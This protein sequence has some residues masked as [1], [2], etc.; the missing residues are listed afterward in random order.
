[1]IDDILRSLLKYGQSHWVGNV[2]GQFC[3]LPAVCWGPRAGTGLLGGQ[4]LIP[5]CPPRF[6]LLCGGSAWGAFGSLL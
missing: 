2:W 5:R 4:T 3:H 1:M 6:L